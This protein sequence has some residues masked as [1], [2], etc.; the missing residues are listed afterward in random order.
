MTRMRKSKMARMRKSAKT[1]SRIYKKKNLKILRGGMETNNDD[2][3]AWKE[4]I[5]KG[6]SF[7]LH[8]RKNDGNTHTDLSNYFIQKNDADTDAD[9]YN[10]IQHRDTRN[11]NVGEYNIKDEIFNFNDKMPE[12]LPGSYSIIN[13]YEKKIDDNFTKIVVIEKITMRKPC[14]NINSIDKITG[15]ECQIAPSYFGPK[16]TGSGE[17]YFADYW[18]KGIK[19][20][21]WCPNNTEPAYSIKLPKQCL[22]PEEIELILNPTNSTKESGLTEEERKAARNNMNGA[23][24]SN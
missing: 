8:L 3:G 23:M 9:T 19:G 5:I 24:M 22:R 11:I 16:P 12:K 17:K 18:E 1:K 21:W 15:L 6:E 10:L 4:C 13:C 2:I 20:W 14:K 7:K